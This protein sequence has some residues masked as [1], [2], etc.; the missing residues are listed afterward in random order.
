[1]QTIRLSRRIHPARL[2]EAL[3]AAG[4]R[5]V[6]VRGGE[7][8]EV[9]LEDGDSADTVQT[10]VAA[11]DPDADPERSRALAALTVLEDPTKP[12]AMRLNVVCEVLAR[13]L[14]ERLNQR[15]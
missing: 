1:M 7:S 4:M 14:R 8:P 11:H 5:V 10:V 12:Q 3:A 6:T 2:H 13:L 15:T 9:V